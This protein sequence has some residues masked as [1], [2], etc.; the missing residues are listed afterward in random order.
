MNRGSNELQQYILEYAGAP[1]Q[2]PVRSLNK[3]NRDI[4]IFSQCSAGCPAWSGKDFFMAGMCF[5]WHG[6]PLE[7]TEGKGLNCVQVKDPWWC[8]SSL[9]LLRND[10]LAPGNAE[11]EAVLRHVARLA[12]KSVQRAHPELPPMPVLQL[13]AILGSDDLEYLKDKALSAKVSD[14][15]TYLAAYLAEHVPELNL[16]P[17]DLSILK[18]IDSKYWQSSEAHK[19]TPELMRCAVLFPSLLRLL[20]PGSPFMS[21]ADVVRSAI[22]NRAMTY[23]VLPE[24]MRRDCQIAIAAVERP[25][26]RNLPD[27][28]KNDKQF[29]MKVVHRDGKGIA[30]ASSALQDD[31]DLVSAAVRQNGESLRYASKALRNDKEIVLA[32][33]RQNG[34]SLRNASEAL[35]D[36]K[37]IVLAAVRQNGESLNDASQAL[38]NDRE[39]VLAAVRQNG[40][41]LGYAPKPLQ[42]D[43]EIVLAAVRQNGESLRFASKALRKQLR[44]M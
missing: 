19:K 43:P 3:A 42:A 11:A 18:W 23:D 1:A 44:N 26:R 37:E 9:I 6:S 21:D 5:A 2:L 34:E 25:G 4:P 39:V 13:S 32:A 29:F 27:D 17:K 10:P 35:R 12:A 40:L 33:V 28:L 20:R 30:H 24:S 7:G 41:N 15:K 22:R 36:D 16:S 14:V 8:L 38:Q 31:K